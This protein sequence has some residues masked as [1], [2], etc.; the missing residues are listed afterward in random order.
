MS[1]NRRS[2]SEPGEHRVSS[3]LFVCG[4][5][6]IRSPMAEAIARSLLPA[7]TYVMSA[8]VHSGER[9]PFVDIV[10][11]ESG[12]SLGNRRPQRFEDLSDSYFDLI[13]T[14][15]PEAHDIALD[16]TG[17]DA[18]AVEFWQMPDPSV[19]TGSRQQIL[20]AYRDV[21]ERIAARIRKRLLEQPS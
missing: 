11:E 17:A 7:S 10:L 2:G 5:N 19:V 4:M 8:G 15:A 16:A 14:M 6:A 3:V 20:D 12:L 18:V 13:V 9:D 1:G 21:R